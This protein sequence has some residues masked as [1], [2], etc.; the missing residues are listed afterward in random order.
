MTDTFGWRVTIDT[1]GEGAFTTSLAKFG[2][3]YSQEIPLGINND[4][5]SIKVS[6]E[7]YRSEMQPVIDF[8]RAHRGQSFFWKPPFGVTGY[9]KC[10]KYSWKDQGGAYFTLSLDFEQ[11]FMP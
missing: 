11:A 10:K 1:S 5:Q 2:D 3:G 4:V 6:V 9:Y 8:I 7:G